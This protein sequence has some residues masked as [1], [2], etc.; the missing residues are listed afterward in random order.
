MAGLQNIVFKKGE[1]KH[2]QPRPYAGQPFASKPSANK[3][4]GVALVT[5]LLI[6]ALV[7]VVAVAMAS[8]QQLDIRRTANMLEADQAY[9]YALAAET[10]VSQVLIEDSQ[11]TQM[12]TLTEA[13][14][15]KLPPIPIEGGVISGSVE[16]MQG[17]F[18]LNSLIDVAGKVDP[19][20]VRVF[21]SLLR[22]LSFSDAKIQL[23]PFVAN[24]LVDWIDP[25][26]NA[27][28]DG[29]EDM[30]YLGLD[31]PYRAANR[32][33]VS[34]SELA[35]IAGISLRDV[36][37]LLPLVTAL[38]RDSAANTTSVINVNTAPEMVL[39]SLS[40]KMT[41]RIAKTLLV[42]RLASPFK[43]V[44]DFVETMQNDYSITIDPRRVG[45]SSEYFLVSSDAAIGRTQLRLY[46]LLS[47]KNNRIT[48]VSRGIGAY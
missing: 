2:W 28:A 3:Q 31:V 20:Q 25:D 40:D 17:R 9:L 26:L 14:A 10:W 42:A 24:R 48:I 13:W 29:A 5:A 21:Q 38:P 44:T 39:I 23:S 22:Q 7:T 15:M 37:A 36:A 4:R 30:L 32:A 8:R 43:N 19:I 11:R 18:N 33:M 12:D 45:V 27:L 46:S 47:R 34:P 1:A 41:P 35:A 6:A 16:D